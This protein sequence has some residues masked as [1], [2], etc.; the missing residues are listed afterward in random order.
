MPA[1][2]AT[3]TPARVVGAAK[4]ERGRRV[5]RRDI[6]SAPRRRPGVT[7]AIPA[8]NYAHFLPGCVA[9]ALS[10]RDV[11]V[12]VLVVDDCS[13][14]DTARV[15]GAL[16]AADPRIAVVR[17]AENE[18]LVRTVNDAVSRVETEYVVKL[19]ADD[20]LAPGAL[21]R[22]TALLEAHPSVVFAYGRPL[23]FSGDPPRTR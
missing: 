12:R 18:G 3:S 21:A 23:H 2:T 6:A 8:Y 22:A 5:V 20:L 4:T 13:T 19:D 14:D 9:T 1:Q 17:H 16:A 15:A 10:Q 11:D 7:I